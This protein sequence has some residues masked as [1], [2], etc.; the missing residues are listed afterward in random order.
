MNPL[1]KKHLIVFTTVHPWIQQ[2]VAEVAPPEFEVKFL[3]LADTQLS[4]ALLP[5]AD[6]VVC[7]ELPTAQAQLLSNCKLVMH[8]GVGYDAVDVVTLHQMGI[9]AAVT[10]AM[11]A[12]GVSEHV[13]M[14]ILAL[15]KQ[16][17][18]VR[19]SMIGGGWN[20][21]GWRQGSHNL[22]GKTLGII[23]L[24]RI[25]KRVAHLA[26]AFGC[27]VVYNDILEMP[28]ALEK[29]YDLQRV[30][31]ATVIAQSD[32]LTL[33]VP[34]TSLTRGMIGAEEFGRMRPGSIFINTSR[35][36]TY[37]LS[38]LHEAIVSGHLFGAGIDVYDPEPPS[39]EHPIFQLPN[40]IAT[41]HIASGTV[42]RQ[43]AI[44]RAQFANC[45]QVLAGQEPDNLIR[46]K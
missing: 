23:G 10:P 41:P 1:S 36:P 16:L 4:Q 9:P 5:K 37:S 11:T 3:D 24:G 18:A 31:F 38:S 19:Q 26:H 25:G 35:G 28:V 34:L 22:H 2:V 21:F 46:M 45:Q 32:I 7:T 39:A 43:Y 30:S 8:N 29:R 27:R 20:M 6:F 15:S 12:E 14:L 13:F 44:N 42:E 40:V 17:P 33:H